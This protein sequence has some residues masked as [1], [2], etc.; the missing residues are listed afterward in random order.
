M[1]N[2]T[3]RQ[4]EVLQAIGRLTLSLGVSPTFRELAAELG[5]SEKAAFDNVTALERKRAVTREKGRSRG[6]VVA[7]ACPCCGREYDTSD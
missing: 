7:G 4:R 1:N 3:D 2:L 6:I 5:I